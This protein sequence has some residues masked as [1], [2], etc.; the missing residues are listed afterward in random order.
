[1]NYNSKTVAFLLFFLP[2]IFLPFIPLGFETPKVFVFELLI[3]ILFVSNLLFNKLSLPKS[4]IFLV[5]LIGIFLVSLYGMVFHYSATI[6]FQNPIRLQGTF[7]FWH[8]LIWTYLSALF[9]F[10]PDSF[11]IAFS[12]LI[13]L[14]VGAVF[15]HEPVT[16]RSVSFLGEPNAL[17]SVTVFFLPFCLFAQKLPLR[18]KTAA[19]LSAIGIAAVIIALSG[20]RS[21]LIAFGIEL[22]L[23]LLFTKKIFSSQLIICIGVMIYIFSL[24]LPFFNAQETWENRSV[25]WQTSL[26]ASQQHPF[27]GVGFGNMTSAIHIA[28]SKSGSN[29]QYVNVDSS[30]NIFLDWLLQGGVIGLFILLLLIVVTLKNYLTSHNYFGVVILFALVTVLSFNPASIVTLVAFWWIIG[31]SFQKS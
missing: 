19:Q 26:V 7:L 11:R 5:S 24:F 18:K 4:R 12:S 15:F 14:L 13:V 25:I 6:F 9:P 1:M 10:K 17:A 28:A 21:G 16:S 27:L 22:F 20:S 29:L 23:W 31:S 3:E 2:F 8:V 30:H